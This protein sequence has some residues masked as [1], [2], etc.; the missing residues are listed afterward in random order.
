MAPLPQSER[1][2]VTPLPLEAAR[3]RLV[4]AREVTVIR[5]GKRL[6]D[7]VTMT[8]TAAEIVTVI[9]PNGAGKTTLLRALMGLIA[10]SS[11]TV[12][13]KPDLRIGYMPQRFAV[14]HTLP[15][16][17]GRF[18]TLTQRADTDKVRASL[19]ETGAAHLINAQVATLSG[20]EFQ[21]VMLARALLRQPDLL[22]L[23]EPT[24]GIDFAGEA[25]FYRLIGR[26]RDTRGCGIL[27]V[28]HDLHV[29]FAASNRVICLNRHI[30]CQGVP[31]D[32]SRHPAYA[33]L[34]GP[35]DAAT[36]GLYAH[37]HDHAHDALSGAALSP[38]NLAMCTG[39]TAEG[40]CCAAHD[41]AR[42]L[43][44]PRRAG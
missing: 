23:D 19:E 36:F 34:F 22:V 29:V 31:E 32:V 1:A 14:D 44:D 25:E 10:P 37:R 11:G 35:R 5:D 39:P 33:R 21:R 2:T 30:C 27:L 12:W 7:R 43:E 15:L 4:A 38:L 41:Q 8:M 13:R 20:G 3:D 6:L 18:M 28:S 26:I 16:A 42:A 24:Q 9:G 17:V 40:G